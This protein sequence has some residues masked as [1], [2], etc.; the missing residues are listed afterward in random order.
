MNKLGLVV[1]MVLI[2]LF[3]GCIC[4][5][6][7]DDFGDKGAAPD[8]STLHRIEKGETSE[9]WVRGALGAPNR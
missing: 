5:S 4:I 3:S 2:A 8:K 1:G 9:Q 7:K 6:N